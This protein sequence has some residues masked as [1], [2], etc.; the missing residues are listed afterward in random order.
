MKYVSLLLVAVFLVGC[1]HSITPEQYELASK[2]CPPNTTVKSIY[3]ETSV[4]SE[5]TVYCT[6][7]VVVR[8]VTE[9]EKA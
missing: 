5:I 8:F 3:V 7:G 4:V 9:R 6:G 1:S 2:M